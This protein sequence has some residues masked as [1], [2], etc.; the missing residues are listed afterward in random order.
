[1]NDQTPIAEIGH[2]NPPAFDP[3]VLAKHI[4]AV[5]E[6]SDAAGEWLERGEITEEADAQMLNDFLAGARKLWKQIEGD[7]VAAK[8]PH[9]DAGKAVQAAY[10]PVLNVLDKTAKKLKP[11]L[12]AFLKKKEEEAERERRAKEEEAR[13]AREEAEKL[14]AQADANNS[15]A[16]E[17]AA[18]QAAECAK[19]L[20]K[21][22]A[23]PAKA[24]VASATGGARTAALRTVRSA[25]I[26]SIRL[27]FSHFQDHSDVVEVLQRVANA[28]VRSKNVDESQIPGIEIVEE[29]V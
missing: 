29:R 14:A 28:A 4:K 24:N 18:E 6:F 17:V 8:K 12:A 26:T 15:I 21:Q 25:K 16:Q 11:V 19:E 1:M 13:R 27:L 9:D 5:D 10:T 20:E 22:A 7:R 3:D 23:K 2:N